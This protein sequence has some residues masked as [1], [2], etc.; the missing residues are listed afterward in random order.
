[1]LGI[2]GYNFLSDINTLDPISTNVD[3]I[4]YL[5]I[6][7][8]VYDHVN[9]NQDVT[10]PMSTVIPTEWTNTTLLDCNFDENISGGSLDEI[11]QDVTAIKIKRRKKGEYN[12][13]TIK[14]I[15]IKSTEDF[16]FAF[17]D[18]LSAS[19]FDYEYA[20]VTITGNTE[21]AY[22][23]NEIKTDFKGVFVC[24]TNTA[25]RF[26]SGVEYGTVATVQKVGVFEPFGRQYP[27]VVSNGNTQYDSGSFS[28]YVFP[29]NFYN[30]NII[31]RHE[32]V[33]ERNNIIKFL[34]NKKP[35]ILKDHNGNCW[36]ICI[37]DKPS[38]SY[39]NNYGQGVVKVEANWV[40]IGDYNN[41]SD[42][43]NANLIPRED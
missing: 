28:G 41:S 42:L 1:M 37:V 18:V 2:I 24:D 15:E 9:L 43:Y 4:T 27:I 31:D 25:Y 13:V 11:A 26:Y 6:M 7:R 5:K 22:N 8:G 10:S 17:N 12:W 23:I 30:D 19:G 40:E 39:D 35:K 3:N 36:L 21:G 14:E 20:Y 33:E 38:T 34:S 16:T 29:S 32:I